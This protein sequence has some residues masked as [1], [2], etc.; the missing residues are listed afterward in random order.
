VFIEAIKKKKNFQPSSK[1]NFFL[2]L[3]PTA[4]K[5]KSLEIKGNKKH[6]TLLFW[7]FGPSS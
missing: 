3:S 5:Q 6:Q 7:L 4:L 1:K 2:A